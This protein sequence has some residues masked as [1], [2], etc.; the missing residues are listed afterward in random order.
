F[1]KSIGETI[2]LGTDGEV[3]LIE[4]FAD[5]T[6]KELAKLGKEIGTPLELTW[7]CYKGQERPC[8]TCGTC[9]ERTESFKLAGYPD[10]A[11]STLEWEQALQHLKKYTPQERR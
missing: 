10:P 6:K 5:K 4:P 2:G 3:E 1:I 9:L 8:L 7:S 11:L